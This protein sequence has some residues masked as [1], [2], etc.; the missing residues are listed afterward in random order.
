MLEKTSYNW[1]NNCFSDQYFSIIHAIKL[2]GYKLNFHVAYQ[3]HERLNNDSNN[4]KTGL[5][6][7]KFN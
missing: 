3:F 5:S 6:S 4:Q 2:I 7:D 1:L